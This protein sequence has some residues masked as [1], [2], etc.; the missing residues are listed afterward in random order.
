MLSWTAIK[1]AVRY[2]FLH[3]WYVFTAC[4]KQGLWWRGLTHD[5]SKL[6]P[7][8]F[9]AYARHWNKKTDP[10]MDPDF[11]RAWHRHQ[12]RNDHHWQWWVCVTSAGEHVPIPMSARARIEMIC[13]WY[14]AGMR[15]GDSDIQGWYEKHKDGMLLHPETREWIER[16]IRSV[17]AQK[18]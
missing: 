11:Q 15:K 8:E 4:A 12:K 14:G 5:L 17:V 13:D 3:K 1:N 18:P 2:L 16:N 10:K 6:R 9:I 7:S